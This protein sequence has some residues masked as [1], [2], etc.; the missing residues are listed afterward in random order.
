MLNTVRRDSERAKRL[1]GYAAV[2]GM[3]M[4][5]DGTVVI[6]VIGPFL[7]GGGRG[8]EGGSLKATSVWENINNMY[9]LIFKKKIICT[10]E[11]S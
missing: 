3:L 10:P 4:L 9:L 8:E 2:S 7:F 6:I 11:I 1:L 5:I